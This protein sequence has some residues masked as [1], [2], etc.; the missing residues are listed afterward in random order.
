MKI[1][2]K[3]IHGS[4]LYGLDGPESDTDFKAIFQPELRDLVLMQA[5]KNETKKISEDVEY[6]G[7]A[8]QS[9]L[10]LAANSEDVAITMLH[11]QKSDILIDSDI[12]EYLRQNRSKFYTKKMIG[13][14]GYAKA[15]ASRFAL[16]ADR[17]NAV[18]KFIELL[19]LAN[20]K[21]V[22]RVGQIWDDLPTGEYYFKGEEETNRQADKRF[23]ECAGKKVTATVAISYALDIFQR[24]YENYGDRVKIAANLDGKDMK[25][26]SHAFRCGFQLKAIYTEG[27]FEY[28]L[29]ETEFI[30]DVKFGRLGYLFHNLDEKLNSLITEVEQLAEESKFPA[31]VDKNFVDDVILDAYGMYNNLRKP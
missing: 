16:R 26:I 5:A 23:F 17:M 24:L 6:E 2:A 25:S 18:K 30:K 20:S 22:A 4:K 14:L 11:V 29:K 19:E 15:Q 10:N 8:L 7:F 28:P 3:C 9:F 1:L 27:Q 12:Y 13:S 31:S 21:G